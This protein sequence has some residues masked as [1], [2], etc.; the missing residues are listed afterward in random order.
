MKKVNAMEMR[1]VEGGAKAT[2]SACGKTAW[3]WTKFLAKLS[4]RIDH[5]GFV[6]YCPFKK[7]W[8][9]VN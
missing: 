8:C 1:N 5:C 6:S 7:T 4:L 9:S 3:G 2:C